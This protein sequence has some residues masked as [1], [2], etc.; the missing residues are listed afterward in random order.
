V[1]RHAIAYHEVSRGT[2]DGTTVHPREVF[3]AA[4]L[5][6]AFGII[7]GHNHPSG[8]PEPSNDDVVLTHRLVAAGELIGIPLFDHIIVSDGR[9]V[10]FLETGRLAG[11]RGVSTASTA[12]DR[13][14]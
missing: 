1:K 2:M 10:S 3:K 12:R 8:D 4:L 9:Y 14:W 7:V 5:A 13:P 11:N 6:N